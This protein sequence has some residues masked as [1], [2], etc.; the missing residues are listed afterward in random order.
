MITNIIHNEDCLTTLKAMPDESIDC[1]VTSPPYFGLRQ[2][3]FDG[4][5]QLKSELSDSERED[6]LRELDRVC[7][8]PKY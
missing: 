6:V 4:A 1:V 8:K 5:V 3:L 7:V 2:Y